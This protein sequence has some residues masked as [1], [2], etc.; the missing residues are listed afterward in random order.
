MMA[1][2]RIQDTKIES[3]S[4]FDSSSIFKLVKCIFY[5]TLS[6][7]Y[8]S[9]LV[10]VSVQSTYKHLSFSIVRICFVTFGYFVKMVCLCAHLIYDMYRRWHVTWPYYRQKFA[11]SALTATTS[12]HCLSLFYDYCIF[13]CKMLVWKKGFCEVYKVL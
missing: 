1:N 10:F 8:Q 6:Y 13:A 9:M 3:Q 5:I 12:G 7:Q 11:H 4:C 2:I